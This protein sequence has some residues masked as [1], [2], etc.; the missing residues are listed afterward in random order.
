MSYGR[1]V[2]TMFTLYRTLPILRVRAALAFLIFFT[3]T[4]LQTPLALVLTAAPHHLSQT[5]VGLF[6]LAG[7]AGALG[8]SLSG[9]LA[10]R[11]KAQAVTGIGLA[12]M[13]A[14]W[15]PIAMLP[16]SLWG[17][18]FGVVVVDY[19]LQS[20]HVANQSLI[21]RERPDAQARLA[22]GY[23][24]FYSLGSATGS[25]LSTLAYAQFGWAGVCILGASGGA[26]AIAFWAA[27]R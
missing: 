2:A 13:L 8:A 20:V 16:Y 15:M 14:A 18:I 26:A 3:I 1:L 10:D 21:Y 7:A 22:A 6:G 12:L 24:V 25:I 9:R 19:G 4:V 17:L 23:M 11:G 27:T 5:Q